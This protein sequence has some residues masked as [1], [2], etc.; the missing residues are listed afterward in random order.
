MG[1]FEIYLRVCSGVAF[2]GT[3]LGTISFFYTLNSNGWKDTTIHIGNKLNQANSK[4][5]QQFFIV[6]SMF[7]LGI[8]DIIL[9][10]YEIFLIINPVK[11]KYPTNGWMRGFILLLTGFT[12]LGVAADLGI[13]AGAFTLLGGVLAMINTSL[14]KCDC[15]RLEKTI[16]TK[17]KIKIDDNEL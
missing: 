8:A 9:A 10:V 1:G 13:A 16:S 7:F 11:F 15:M 12:V 5:N 4:V 17:D 2:I 14:I 3:V 6:I